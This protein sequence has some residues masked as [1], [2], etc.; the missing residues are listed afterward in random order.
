MIGEIKEEKEFGVFFT[1]GC[2]S[3][4]NC[5]RVSISESQIIGL[6]RRRC[7]IKQRKEC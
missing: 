3:S 5:N 7:Q 2:R 6:N 1:E 4:L